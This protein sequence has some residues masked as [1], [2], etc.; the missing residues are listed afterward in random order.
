[1]ESHLQPLKLCPAF[2]GVTEDDVLFQGLQSSADISKILNL[3]GR[4][5]PHSALNYL[6]TICGVCINAQNLFNLYSVTSESKECK[7]TLCETRSD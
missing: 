5:M 6:D 1:M 2:A 3:M 4:A 7:I